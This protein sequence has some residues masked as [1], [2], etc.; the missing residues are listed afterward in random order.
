MI[1]SVPDTD[2]RYYLL[3]ML[4]MWTDVFAVPGKRTSGTNPAHY[5][6]VPQAGQASCRTVLNASTLRLPMSGLLVEHKRTAQRTLQRSTKFRM[7]FQVTLLADWG[8]SPRKPVQKIDPTVDTKTEPLVQVNSMP[9]KAYF[10]YACEL[11][12]T[13]PPHLTDWSIIERMKHIGIVPGKPFDDSKVSEEV[14]NKGAESGLKLIAVQ[15]ANSGK[16]CEW[17]ADEH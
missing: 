6:V 11:M 14:L 4:D 7:A 2:G 9:A 12:K 5:G 3:P 10:Q 17:L 8:K 13:S 16:S 15:G 1:V